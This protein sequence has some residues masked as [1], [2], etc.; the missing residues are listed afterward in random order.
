M[1]SADVELALVSQSSSPGTSFI[2][3][4][5]ALSGGVWLVRHALT[6]SPQ[7]APPSPAEEPSS[8]SSRA[9]DFS[10]TNGEALNNSMNDQ[11]NSVQ[12]MVGGSYD[13]KTY[14]P[15]HGKK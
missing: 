5:L 7:P 6:D 13:G 12:N 2:L 8:T 14:V 3:I 9:V 10:K 15:P 1:A 11:L 4:L